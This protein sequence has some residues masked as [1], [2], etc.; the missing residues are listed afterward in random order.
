MLK[1]R[2]NILPQTSFENYNT[3]LERY[4]IEN[5]VIISREDFFVVLGHIEK[6]EDL[7]QFK[8]F[9]NES[10]GKIAIV[11]NIFENS[12]EI[13]KY[14]DRIIVHHKFQRDILLRMFLESTQVIHI[15]YPIDYKG[16][17]EPPKDI[18]IYI[19][20]DADDIKVVNFLKENYEIVQKPQESS[21]IIMAYKNEH[22]GN[23]HTFY[24]L[25][26]YSRPFILP[27]FP[28]FIEFAILKATP[29]VLY[30]NIESLQ[31]IIESFENKW[32]YNYYLSIIRAYAISNSFKRFSKLLLNVI[33]NVIPE[34][35]LAIWYS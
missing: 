35:F 3:I 2:L 15:D 29:E 20:Q 34:D 24:K 4:L 6:L 26:K 28:Q 21:L 9:K 13:L 23:Y 32:F 25:F 22:F 31:R 12:N 11:H 7:E 33:R 18:K 10:I 5:D 1:I 17:N 14:V 19:P 27:K 30:D 8:I 16:F